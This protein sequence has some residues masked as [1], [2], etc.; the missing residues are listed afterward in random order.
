MFNLLKQPVD[1][2]ALNS[3]QILINAKELT[4]VIL[5]TSDLEFIKHMTNHTH[6]FDA[7]QRI[8]S[9]KSSKLIDLVSRETTQ[10]HIDQI[11]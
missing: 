9:I 5:D 1:K 2:I 11:F 6:V 4:K 8:N 7:I 10:Q 3:L